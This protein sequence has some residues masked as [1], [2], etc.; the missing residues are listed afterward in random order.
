MKFQV[1]PYEVPRRT[2]SR[3][4]VATSSPKSLPA[5]ALEAPNGDALRR[6]LRERY[7]QQGRGIRSINAVNESSYVV[8]VESK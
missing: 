2:R 3:R 4:E 1:K 6:M 7:A 5:F 8:Y